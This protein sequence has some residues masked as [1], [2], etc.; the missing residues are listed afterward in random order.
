MVSLSSNAVIVIANSDEQIVFNFIL[1]PFAASTDLNCSIIALHK[2][3]GIDNHIN[4]LILSDNKRS[5]E[6]PES[7]EKRFHSESPPQ[8]PQ[9]ESQTQ[10]ESQPYS[11]SPPQTE[12]TPHTDTPRSKSYRR[13]VLGHNIK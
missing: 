5:P 2:Y 9:N 11:E 12:S 4:S 7:S 6:S 13:G 8:T 1:P 10:N 3:K